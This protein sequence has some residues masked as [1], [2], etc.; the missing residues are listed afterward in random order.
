L[1]K[2]IAL[3][4]LFFLFLTLSTSTAYAANAHYVILWITDESMKPRFKFDVGE[5]V[6]IHWKSDRSVDVRVFQPGGGIVLDLQNQPEQGYVTFTPSKCGFY[7]IVCGSRLC[8]IAI[9]MIF[10]VP[11][12]PFGAVTA[13]ALSLSALGLMWL[14]RI[15][16]ERP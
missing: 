1:R 11:D 15:R 9:G 4:A 13:T 3:A 10:V 2:A 5:T 6:Y 16:K 12:L 8:F 7:L 14:R